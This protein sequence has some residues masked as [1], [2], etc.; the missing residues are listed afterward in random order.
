MSSRVVADDTHCRVSTAEN[1]TSHSQKLQ[2]NQRLP[3]V[4]KKVCKAI[5]LLSFI[6]KAIKMQSKFNFYWYNPLYC[7]ILCI[8]VEKPYDR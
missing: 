5:F 3:E 1:E 7:K 6:K 2:D 4:L 8:I